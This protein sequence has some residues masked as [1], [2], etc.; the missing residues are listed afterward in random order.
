M[1]L[2]RRVNRDSSHGT[3]GAELPVS[4]RSPMETARHI[5]E[6]LTWTTRCIICDVPGCLLCADCLSKLHFIDRWQACP[7]CGAPFGRLICTECNHFTLQQRGLE[8]LPYRRCASALVHDEL[9]RLVITTYKDAGERRM[10]PFMA[11]VCAE[12]LSPSVAKE[13]HAIVY[14]PSSR[15][16]VARRGFDHAQVVAEQLSDY[17]D[18][19]V[20]NL[21]ERPKSADQRGLNRLQRQ[22]NMRRAVKLAAHRSA[23]IPDRIIVYDDVYTTGATICAASEALRHAGCQEVT[24]VTF[25]R[26]P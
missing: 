11:R 13:S 12:T 14:I 9:S 10:A 15:K 21:F 16:A 25:S 22:E 1:Y 4:A 6:E 23:T 7:R 3:L 5:L 26:V 2:N 8:H 24:C 17:L 20:A 18:T 19:P